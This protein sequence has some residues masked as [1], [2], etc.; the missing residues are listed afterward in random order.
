M[1]SKAKNCDLAAALIET[2]EA[3]E[4]PTL[5]A[6]PASTASE[7]AK[8]KGQERENTD[9]KKKDGRLRDA[10]GIGLVFY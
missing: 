6:T 9:A 8:E 7:G 10:R 5:I 1:R 2:F 3:F 4:Q